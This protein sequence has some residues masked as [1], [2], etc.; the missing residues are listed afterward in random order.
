MPIQL[1]RTIKALIIVCFVAFIVQQTS[2]RFLGTH[3]LSWFGLVPAAFIQS[4][5]YWQIFT[6]AFL[7]ADVMHLF[8]NMLMLAFIGSE[9][10]ITW[11]RTQFLRYFIFCTVM[12]ALAYLVLQLVILKDPGYGLM[13]GASGGIY[14]LL[15]AY[16]LI[17]GERVL[18][19]MMLFPMKAK[20]F[21]LV[22][23]LVELM[24]TM[25]S[26]GGPVASGAHLAGMAAGFF[27]LWARARW[28][29]RQKSRAKVK[30]LGFQLKRKK[31]KHL[32]LVVNKPRENDS[33]DEGSHGN[34]R[35]W[36]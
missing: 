13:V 18:L 27:Y 26:S 3:F 8:F 5:R 34:P 12:A 17:F 32:K 4:H 36:H 6:Y 9:L 15:M 24:T 14:G 30:M 28:I 23:A 21:V 29:I 11:G 25:Y 2:D 31:S 16:G 33:S 10:E 7:H 22:L 35:T 20:H 1:T 19:F